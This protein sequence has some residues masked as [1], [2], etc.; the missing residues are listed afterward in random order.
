[1]FAAMIGIAATGTGGIALA[2]AP[3]ATVAMHLIDANGV[4]ADAGTL[5]L[6]DSRS[7]LR[8]KASLKGLPPG[9]HG[10]HMHEKPSCDPAEKEGKMAAGI[11]AG[12]HFD[13]DTTGKHMGPKGAGH[14]GDLPLLHVDA[15][16]NAHATLV[17]PHLK[18]ADA[19]GKAFVIHA[20]SDNYSDQPQPLG[21]GGARIACGTAE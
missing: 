2:K 10:F 20:G 16:G 6:S 9:D 19:H 21:G 11:G 8:I 7:G 1:M 17:A 4:G 18:L 3:S 15:K 12:G 14:R 5:T 13:P